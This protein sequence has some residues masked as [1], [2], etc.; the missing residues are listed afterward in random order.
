MG[1]MCTEAFKS[2]RLVAMHQGSFMFF[3]R[4]Q[5][6]AGTAAFALVTRTRIH[7][8][9][10]GPGDIRATRQSKIAAEASFSREVGGGAGNRTRVR[11]ASVRPSFTCVAGAIRQQIS[12]IRPTT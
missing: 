5:T 3:A 6:I 4:T 2:L 10:P 7:L 1:E 11:K 9:P 12:W 8:G